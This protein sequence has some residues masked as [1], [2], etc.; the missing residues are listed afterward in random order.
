MSFKIG[1]SVKVQTISGNFIYGKVIGTKESENR[2]NIWCTNGGG[3]PLFLWAYVDDI[4]MDEKESCEIVSCPRCGG[5]TE[6]RISQSLFGEEYKIN[7]C[8][9]GWC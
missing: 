5:K 7:K 2:Y 9:C 8:K 3:R 6:R 4:L 1:D